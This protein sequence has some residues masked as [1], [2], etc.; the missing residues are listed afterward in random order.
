MKILLVEDDEHKRN[1]VSACLMS[2]DGDMTIEHGYSVASGVQMAVD[3][4]YDLLLLDMAIPNFD[5]S[6]GSNGGRPFKKGGELIVEELLDEGVD[7]RC[8][9]IT[10]YETFNNET[11]DEIG[12]RLSELCGDKYFGYVKYS[13]MNEDWKDDLKKLIQ[14]V[15]NTL[16][17]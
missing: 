5:Q 2:V 14:H 15:K 16:H 9:I 4:Q 13:T 6:N 12:Q 17:R 10:Q 3:C 7:F 11:I 8:A 1:D